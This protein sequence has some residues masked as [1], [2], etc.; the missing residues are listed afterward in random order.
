MYTMSLLEFALFGLAGCIV[1]QMLGVRL[2]RHI[3]QILFKRIVLFF[4]A[5]AAVILFMRALG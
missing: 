5:I 4:L 3:D 1:G 2:G